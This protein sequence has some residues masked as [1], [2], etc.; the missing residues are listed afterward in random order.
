MAS[1]KAC[2]S[3]SR[4]QKLQVVKG[5]HD[6]LPIDMPQWLAIE[7]AYRDTA[8][9][10]GFGEIRT[11]VVES[12]E[13]FSRGVG[14]TTD[15]V[16]KEMYT[17]VDKGDKRLTMRPEGTASSVRAYI[18][19]GIGGQE[20]ISKWIYAGPMFRRERPAKGRY[21]QF[22]Q[23]GAEI[24][25]AP[26]PFSDAE[27]IDM[28]VQFLAAVGVDN[29]AVELNS[30]GSG[31]SRARYRQALLD[32]LRPHASELSE[33]SQRRLE[34]NPLRVLDSKVPSDQKIAAGAPGVLEH[35][36]QEDREHF[37]TLQGLLR[38]FGLAVSINQS[39]VRGLDYY[40]R[41][42]FEV[43]D[44]SGRLGAQDTICG[45]G[46][47]DGLVELLGGAS[48]P[49]VGFAIGIERLLMSMA[50]APT[51]HPLDAF[52]VVPQAALRA[53]AA[54]L[55][56]NLRQAG[57]CVDADYRGGSLKSQMRRADKSGAQFAVI[58]GEDELA[59]GAVQL[60][61]L[62]TKETSEVTLADAA[63]RIA[64]ERATSK[65]EA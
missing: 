49:A 57:L 30:I 20:P 62:Q 12:T 53:Q 28:L 37:E 19:H 54:T 60:R 48:V 25:G 3:V 18:Q 22:Y 5:M 4:M 35:L 31:D 15:I 11:P 55:A 43:K 10:F 64:K 45:G 42:V 56:R 1:P 47:Y 21:R 2:V 40:T 23:L 39:L 34:T 9:R 58:V 8:Q 7:Q 51:A 33:D 38:D 14:E 50:D 63:T 41:T 61:N 24:F 44:K 6:V 27:L 32:Y 36:G 46:R 16:Q 17:F 26:G 65:S 59:R 52:V 29:V 13:L